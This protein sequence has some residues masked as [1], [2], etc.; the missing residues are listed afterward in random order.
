MAGF[1][2]RRCSA[3]TAAGHVM[4]QRAIVAA[5]YEPMLAAE[6]AERQK[7]G[8]SVNGK[9]GGLVNELTKGRATQQAA[10]ITGTNRQ[11]VAEAKK[12]KAEAPELLEEVRVGTRTLP[13]AAREHVLQQSL[14]D[15]PDGPTPHQQARESPARRWS[16]ER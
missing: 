1:L 12:L 11:Y 4:R 16:A 5:E 2:A 13:E 9:T 6:A 14:K 15:L 3:R 7:A 10:N 8:K